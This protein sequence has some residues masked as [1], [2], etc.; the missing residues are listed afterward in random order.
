MVNPVPGMIIYSN[1]A[2]RR[3]D[4]ESRK[5]NEGEVLVYAELNNGSKVVGST[6]DIV[7]HLSKRYKKVLY[8]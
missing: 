3:D 2:P 8:C 5:E 1:T 4:A 7:S 6:Q